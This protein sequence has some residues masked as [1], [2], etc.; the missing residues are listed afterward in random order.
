M[1]AEPVTYYI[2]DYLDSGDLVLSMIEELL[3]PKYS[4]ITF[5]CHN[6]GGYDVVFILKSISI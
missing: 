3:H 6:I 2:N 1:A 4:N 5:Y